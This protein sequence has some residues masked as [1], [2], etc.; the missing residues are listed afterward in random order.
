MTCLPRVIPSQQGNSRG[1]SKRV[2][3]SLV[4]QSLLRPQGRNLLHPDYRTGIKALI[5]LYE[6][7]RIFDPLNTALQRKQAVNAAV[8][9]NKEYYSAT[10]ISLEERSDR[11]A[12]ENEGS[13]YSKFLILLMEFF[14]KLE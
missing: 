3:N 2:D 14:I 1:G 6:N 13:P 8:S 4:V 12:L 9:A 7:Q 10:T 11:Q 5:Q